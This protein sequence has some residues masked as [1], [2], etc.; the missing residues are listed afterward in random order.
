ML[1]AKIFVY[2]EPVYGFGN[3]L[4]Y[5]SDISEEKKISKRDEFFNVL[6]REYMFNVDMVEDIR[7]KLDSGFCLI[8]NLIKKEV[9]THDEG[10]IVL[11][12]YPIGEMKTRDLKSG[13]DAITKKTEN[14]V[15]DSFFKK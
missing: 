9:Y 3:R 8:I 14:I 11:S 15:G 6:K 5:L 4:Q 12:R 7:V 1:E 2:L 10:P 13:F